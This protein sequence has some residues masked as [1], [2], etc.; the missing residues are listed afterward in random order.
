[1]LRAA[2]LFL[3]VVIAA[4]LLGVLSVGGM[5]SSPTSNVVE[6]PETFAWAPETGDAVDASAADNASIQA[7]ALGI[8]A[9]ES[10]HPAVRESQALA[11]AGQFEEATTLLTRAIE[12]DGG[13][14]GLRNALGNTLLKAGDAEAAAEAFERARSLSPEDP[15]YAYNAGL[16]EFRRGDLESSI[17]HF[18]AALDIN[19][20][21]SEARYNLALAYSRSGLMKR[22]ETEYR[23]VADGV[24]GKVGQ[25]ARFNL[26]VILMQ[27][28]RLDEALEA[29]GSVLYLD[30]SNVDARF[31]RALLLARLGLEE[32]AKEQ[33][34]RLLDLRPDHLRARLNLAALYMQSGDCNEANIH[35]E[36]LV[37]RSPNYALAHYN[38]GVCALRA[39]RA[40]EAVAH[41]RAA[42]DLEPE[43]AAGHYNLALAAARL[44]DLDVG[45]EGYAQA[46]AYAPERASYRYNYAGLLSQ[47]GRVA[48]ALEQY[49][50]AIELKPDYFEAVYNAGLLHLR[51]E[52][53]AS[54]E[55]AFERALAIRPMSYETLYNQGLTR[56]KS[57]RLE[58]AETSLLQALSL[59]STVPATYNLGLALFRQGR[60]N[61]AAERYEAALRIDPKHAAS[62][63][64]LAETMTDLGKHQR[65]LERLEQLGR[66]DPEDPTALN[67]GLRLMKAGKARTA[68]RYLELATTFRDSLKARYNLAAVR[69][70]LGLYDEA[71]EGFARLVDDAPE[72]ELYIEKL[73]ESLFLLERHEDSLLVIRS[74]LELD[75]GDTAALNFGLRLLRSDD[76]ANAEQYLE[77]ASRAE[78]AFKA[79]YNLASAQI[80]LEN[81]EEA[82]VGLRSLVSDAPENEL[83]VERLAEVL[84]ELGRHD[85]SIEVLERLLALDPED[86]AAMNFGI[87]LLRAEQYAK[88]V[89][90]LEL[91]ASSGS[92][93]RPRSLELIGRSL[94]NLD[95]DAA[96]RHLMK[97]Q[98]EFP[99]HE[100]I[101]SRLKRVRG[102]IDR[103][104][105]G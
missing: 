49:E 24:R 102:Q 65:A 59:E 44:D 46:V 1:M 70:D 83:Y 54:A 85:E 61:D 34:R 93:V 87:R 96:L 62:L 6:V 5:I 58:E 89:E 105:P 73:A 72:D 56:L 11:A 28:G 31:N 7:E 104:R 86:T 90:Y 17:D 64:R 101:R 47:A 98:Q 13:H 82:Q 41:L 40:E 100:G 18:L 94:S 38:L 45:L 4:L 68:E 50:A 57:G 75:P 74:L 36:D 3:N 103:V 43:M 23:Q 35:L 88:S 33:Y 53:F 27:S 97:A 2:F 12:A 21:Y 30:A 9:V 37:E 71:R 15:R 81:L 60:L 39:D 79:R 78:N 8:E 99:E 22:A 26:G 16:A 92:K 14:A 55:T 76:P 10:N 69:M 25:T 48:E 51:V 19:P 66:M 32:E 91:A 77:L 52:D 95:L 67:A 42:V 84:F 20:F 29:F 80:A 63:E